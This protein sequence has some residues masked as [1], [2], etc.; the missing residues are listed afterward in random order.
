[1]APSWLGE[2]PVVMPEAPDVGSGGALLLWPATAFAALAPPLRATDDARLDVFEEASLGLIV[3]GVT[4]PRA[5]AELV[6][7]DHRLVQH[8]LRQLTMRHLVKDGEVTEHGLRELYDGEPAIGDA[9]LGHVF[10]DDST[11]ELWPRFL[12]GSLPFAECDWSGGGPMVELGSVGRPRLIRATFVPPPQSQASLPPKHAEIRQAV[13]QHRRALGARAIG[14]DWTGE[15]RLIDN[16]G[17]H[18]FLLLALIPADELE[19]GQ[20]WA[21][22]DPF[23]GPNPTLNN[24]VATRAAENAPL[25]QAIERAAGARRREIALP[26]DDPIMSALVALPAARDPVF[27]IRRAL[28]DVEANPQNQLRLRNAAATIEQQLAR[29]FRLLLSAHPP[30]PGR[31]SAVVGHAEYLRPLL[32]DAFALLGFDPVPPS[33]MAVS[34]F[35]VRAAL[36]RGEGSARALLLACALAALDHPGHPLRTLAQSWPHVLPE[37]AEL[38]DAAEP[39]HRPAGH[40]AYKTPPD[41]DALR[42]YVI[43]VEQ[44]VIASSPRELLHLVT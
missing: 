3:A 39:A 12:E 26:A 15:V 37:I 35:A 14:D 1:M 6:R 7:L 33:L 31:R 44:L 28:A 19:T 16:V 11:G 27:E 17:Q 9:V 8:I 43:V 40:S 18:V 34:P 41:T 21:V 30:H 32:V 5:I 23:G 4:D 20:A 29:I 10:R 13:Q 36:E 42:R 24:W 25:E 2:M 22:V 38:L